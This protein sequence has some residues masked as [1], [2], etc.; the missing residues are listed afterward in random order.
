MEKDIGKIKKNDITDI[1]V[2]ID[3]FGGKKGLTIREFTTSDRYTGFTKSGTRIAAESFNEFKALINSIDPKDLEHDPNAA[4]PEK[5]STTKPK[6]KQ[7]KVS[8][9]VPEESLF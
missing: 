2:R 4:P 3:D 5:K 8:D 1:V 9:D 7:K 6:E